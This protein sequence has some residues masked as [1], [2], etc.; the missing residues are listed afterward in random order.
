MK[1]VI[2]G[3]PKEIAALAVVIKERYGD[4][5]DTFPALLRILTQV[6]DKEKPL[7]V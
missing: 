7:P 4:K 6:N 3:K 1:I 5:S 2:K